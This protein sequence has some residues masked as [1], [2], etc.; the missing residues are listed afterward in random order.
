MFPSILINSESIAMARQVS[1]TL[2]IGG[3]FFL[4]NTVPEMIHTALKKMKSICPE[5]NKRHLP[6][7]FS[8]QYSTPPYRKTIVVQKQICLGHFPPDCWNSGISVFL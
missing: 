4:K 7:S 2:R 5:E 3:F 6:K 1:I 8:R